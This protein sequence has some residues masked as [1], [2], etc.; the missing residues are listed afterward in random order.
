MFLF[1]R[2]RDKQVAFVVEV[3]KP[4][5]FSMISHRHGKLCFTVNIC[6]TPTVPDRR[7]LYKVLPR[8]ATNI[9]LN[10]SVSSLCS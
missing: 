6:G 9:F 10:I 1:V 8:H 2:C 4:K 3:I 5:I 7:H